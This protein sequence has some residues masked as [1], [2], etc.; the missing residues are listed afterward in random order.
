MA[1]SYDPNQKLVT[2]VDQETNA[3]RTYDLSLG[4]CSDKTLVWQVRSPWKHMVQDGHLRR[5]ESGRLLALAGCSSQAAYV[6]DAANGQ[7]LWQ[8]LDGPDCPHAMELL[9]GDILV[10]AGSYGNQIRFYDL[11]GSD[12]LLGAL[13]TEDPHGLL[14]DPSLDRLWMLGLHNLH[15]L[16]IDR[17]ADGSISARVEKQWPLPGWGGHDL[18]PVYGSGGQRLWVTD[19]EGVYQFSIPEETFDT[20]YPGSGL[21]NRPNTKAIGN[22]PDGTVISLTP[23]AAFHPWTAY[24][25]RVFIP[26]G[27][28]FRTQDI[29]IPGMASYKVRVW[30]AEYQDDIL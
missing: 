10:I 13:D 16:K 14:Y 7:I 5:D 25:F 27:D 12:R 3:L 22:Y 1:F 18:Y 28:G 19:V 24:S 23:D 15:L 4:E 11:H 8:T 9:P 17:L 2:L 26:D 20:G 21:I 29:S 30:R 6:A